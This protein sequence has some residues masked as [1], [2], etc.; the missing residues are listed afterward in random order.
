[1][2]LFR[3]LG[4]KGS[5]SSERVLRFLLFVM[6]LAGISFLFWNNYE[7]SIRRI[8]TNQAVLDRTGQL[9]P[10][11]RDE[12]VKFSNRMRE[13]YGIVV[14]VRIAQRELLAPQAD[15]KTLFI[16]IV[17]AERQAV[18][19]LPPLMER[20]LDPGFVSYLKQDHFRAYWNQENGWQ[21]GLH[22]AMTLLWD[23]MRRLERA[24]G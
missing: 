10:E 12:V 2:S 20:A 19:L 1:M 16:G 9:S 14:E 23:Q 24:N 21:E 11:R 4:P 3:R 5:T 22:Q 18:F 15:A 17:P 6:L 13:H 8:S 7:R